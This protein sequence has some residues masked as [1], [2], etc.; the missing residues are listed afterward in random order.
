VSLCDE[1]GQNHEMTAGGFAWVTPK[2]L[3]PIAAF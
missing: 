3:F 2:S 1:P